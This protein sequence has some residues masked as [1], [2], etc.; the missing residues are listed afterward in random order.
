[1]NSY[2]RELIKEHIKKNGMRDFL[3]CVAWIID[4]NLGKDK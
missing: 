2:L 1:M 4:E 3:E